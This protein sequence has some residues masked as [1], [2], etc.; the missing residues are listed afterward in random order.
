[1]KILVNSLRITRNEP[2]TAHSVRLRAMFIFFCIPWLITS[3]RRWLSTQDW[4]MAQL[5]NMYS[6][7]ILHFLSTAGASHQISEIFRQCGAIT[8]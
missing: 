6:Q 3:R 7:P 1:M 5:A 2:K 4:N 8:V